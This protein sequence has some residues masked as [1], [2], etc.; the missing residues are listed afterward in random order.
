LDQNLVE[1]HLHVAT[2]R[3]KTFPCAFPRLNFDSPSPFSSLSS[4]AVAREY[5]VGTITPSSLTSFPD[6]YSLQS[7]YP[8]FFLSL[9]PT[10]LR[11]TCWCGE[12]E[13]KYHEYFGLVTP[14]PTFSTQPQSYIQTFPLTDSVFEASPLPQWFSSFFFSPVFRLFPRPIFFLPSQGR[15]GGAP[16][17]TSPPSKI[18]SFLF[19]FLFPGS[20]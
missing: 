1:V 3:L 6:F 19:F 18:D 10:Y 13:D 15:T 2:P 5:Q 9:P 16:R 20:L 14:V 12:K 7:G 8:P 17:A 4:L 11:V